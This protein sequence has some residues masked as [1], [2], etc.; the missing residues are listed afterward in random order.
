MN[1]RQEIDAA[2]TKAKHVLEQINA[3]IAEGSTDLRVGPLRQMQASA[4]SM[5]VNL[6][7]AK[8]ILDESGE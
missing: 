8:K 1:A 4:H 2:L 7:M 3:M 6:A 5:V